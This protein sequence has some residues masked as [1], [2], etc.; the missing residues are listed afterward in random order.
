MTREIEVTLFARARD[1]AG[2]DKVKLS[3]PDTATVADLRMALGEEHPELRPYLK[4]LLIALGNDYA[5]DTMPL[6]GHQQAA[7][8][9]PVSGG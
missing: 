3:L 7:C 1:L 9:P 4:N 2:T 6:A 5:D 8:F